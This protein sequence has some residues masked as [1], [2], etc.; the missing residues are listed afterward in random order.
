M[1][2]VVAIPCGW[3]DVPVD[4]DED[5]GQVVYCTEDHARMDVYGKPTVCPAG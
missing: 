3:C 2:D 1:T 5:N 4:V